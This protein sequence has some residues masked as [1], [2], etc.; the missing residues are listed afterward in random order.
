MPSAASAG[1][2]VIAVAR[3]RISVAAVREPAALSAV[4]VVFAVVI[5]VQRRV[6]VA[7]I[8]IGDA[9]PLH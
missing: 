7:I 9:D 3:P 5:R 4:E 2:A 6:H 1:A 8:G